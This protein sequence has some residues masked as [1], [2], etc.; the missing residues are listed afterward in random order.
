LYGDWIV[1]DLLNLPWLAKKTSEA[2]EVLDSRQRLEKT[3]LRKLAGFAQMK[4]TDRDVRRLAKVA[5]T[6]RLEV[7]DANLTKIRL[8][9]ACQATA[10][11]LVDELIV[12]GLRFGLL[13]DILE[14][15]FNQ[16][17]DL[18]YG[19]YF[20]DE[21]RRELD[22]TFVGLDCRHLGF[23]DDVAGDTE[24]AQREVVEKASAI[25]AICAGIRSKT[26]APCIIQNL[27]AE[28]P[29]WLGSLDRSISGSRQW[30]VDSV[31]EQIRAHVAVSSDYLFDCE[32]LASQ[33]GLANW[34][35]PGM[36]YL[37]KLGFAQSAVPYFAHRLAA[38]IAA[39]KGKSRRVLVLDLDNTLWGGVIGDDGVEGIRI[40]HGSAAGEA[41]LDVQRMAK[42]LKSRG[43]VLTVCSKNDEPVAKLAFE[44]HS[45]MDL[46]LDDFAAFRANW[47]D[48]ASNIRHI[49][50]LLNLGL[51]SFVLVDDN[52]VEREIVRRTLPEVAVPEIGSDPAEYARIVMAAGYFESVS[53]NEE[54]R[55]RAQMYRENVQRAGAMEIVADMDSYLESLDMQLRLRPFDRAG[56]DRIVQLINKSNQF[57]LTTRRYS[58][59]EVEAL[60][61]D[62]MVFTLQAS[63]KDKFGDNGMISVVICRPNSGDWVIDTWLMSC[64]VLKRRVEEQILDFVVDSGRKAGAKRLIGV[65]RPTAKNGLVK[66]HYR[67]LGFEPGYATDEEQKWWLTI[68]DAA[69]PSQKLPFELV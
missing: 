47:E 23:R 1:I 2:T 53:F 40:G 11:L 52:P 41:F 56:R 37:A 24:A 13:I 18:A 66:N 33:I 31:N 64:R 15:E 27:I 69:H 63:L 32:H 12:A 19:S 14:T 43:I 39:A 7:A 42:L 60:E 49:G 28:E 54:D 51:D 29:T 4:L 21:H 5:R 57:N 38:L 68:G 58:A 50:Q 48:K 46:R 17:A 10:D 62:P 61:L 67:D 45:G 55:K 59:S 20:D 3:P 44:Q 34:H 6:R 26:G 22:F 65:Y 9:L 16:L 36:W 30:L 25:R 8:C 35:D